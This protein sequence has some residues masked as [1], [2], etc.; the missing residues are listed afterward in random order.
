V[1]P[2]PTVSSTQTFL[3][4]PE[5]VKNKKVKKEKKTTELTSLTFIHG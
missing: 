1:H 5:K 3:T 4:H 2:N